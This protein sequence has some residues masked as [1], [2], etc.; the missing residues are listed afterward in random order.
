MSSYYE[1]AYGSVKIGPVE[2]IILYFDRQAR[3]LLAPRT[4]YE[5]SPKVQALT[6]HLE[7]IGEAKYD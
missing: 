7:A 6:N 5:P 2:S 1:T 3:A 4:R